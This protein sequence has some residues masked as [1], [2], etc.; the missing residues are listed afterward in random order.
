MVCRETGTSPVG[1]DRHD[2]ARLL[3]HTLACTST[4]LIRAPQHLRFSTSELAGGGAMLLLTIIRLP[5]TS[6]L[7]VGSSSTSQSVQEPHRVV[8]I[9]L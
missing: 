6:L 8:A 9:I 4:R 1:L 3:R 5:V 7:R 2:G